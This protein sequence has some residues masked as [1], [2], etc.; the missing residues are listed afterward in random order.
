MDRVFPF[1]YT[2]VGGVPTA[3]RARRGRGDFLGGW[4]FNKLKTKETSAAEDIEDG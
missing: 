2:Q 3:Q 1:T 4:G